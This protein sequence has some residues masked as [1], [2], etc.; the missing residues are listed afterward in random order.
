MLAWLFAHQHDRDGSRGELL[1]R[2]EDLDTERDRSPVAARQRTDLETLGLSFDPPQVVQSDRAAVYR[3]ALDRLC[4]RTYECFC[5]RREIAEASSAPHGAQRRYPGTCRN[6]TPAQRDF[7]RQSRPPAIRLRADPVEVTIS[8]V[9]RGQRTGLADDIVLV[10]NNG[11]PAYH[12]AVVTDDTQS[13]VNQVV[14][15]D[16]LL[17]AAISQTYL[18]RLL[19]SPPPQYAHVPL[20]LNPDGRRLAKRDGAV[21]LADLQA[22]GI[23]PAQTVSMLAASLNL[24]DPGE[25]LTMTDVLDRF[26][27]A[28]LPTQPWVYH[29]AMSA[30]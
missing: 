26:D 2:I 20:V 25:P 22:R 8:D 7:R 13:G 21:T 4:G 29:P 14:R 6:L 23:D 18:A 19:G 24:A 9:L 17:D 11:T 30:G 1:Y 12:L 3:A 16:D 15:G 27:P 10:R 5:S 28:L